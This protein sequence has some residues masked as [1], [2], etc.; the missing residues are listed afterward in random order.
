MT[1]EERKALERRLYS[2]DDAM[3][4][5]EE[6]CKIARQIEAAD[7]GRKVID[8]GWMVTWFAN[9]MQTAIDHYKRR[10]E[11]VADEDVEEALEE[12]AL[13]KAFAQGRD[14]GRL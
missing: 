12:D 4:W 13:D 11:Q 10:A 6:W 7:D 2:T 14:E 8:E 9:A 5:A 3:V 1:G